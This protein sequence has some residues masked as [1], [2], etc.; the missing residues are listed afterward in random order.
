MQHANGSREMNFIQG[1]NWRWPERH[2]RRLP[3]QSAINIPSRGLRK[4]VFSCPAEM[5]Y[6]S[7]AELSDIDRIARTR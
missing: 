1:W 6:T 4:Q 2:E 7:V 3:L 5:R